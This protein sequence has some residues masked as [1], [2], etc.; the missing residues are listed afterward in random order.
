MVVVTLGVLTL[1][2][3]LQLTCIQEQ[4]ELLVHL[5]TKT[6]L[7]TILLHLIVLVLPGIFMHL[8]MTLV[9]YL[10]RQPREDMSLVVLI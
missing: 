6:T 4:A 8:V 9:Q 2:I 7:I 10:V 1:H 5:L 3:P